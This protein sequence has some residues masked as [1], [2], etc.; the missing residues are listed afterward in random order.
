M[1]TSWGQ[2]WEQAEGSPVWFVLAHT[3]LLPKPG[4]RDRPSSIRQN[5]LHPG[6]LLEDAPHCGVGREREIYLLSSGL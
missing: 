2:S 6:G 4:R 5:P 3:S 1:G